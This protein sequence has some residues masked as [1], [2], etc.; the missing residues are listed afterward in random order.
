[1]NMT[2]NVTVT[3]SFLVNRPLIDRSIDP[4][5]LPPTCKRPCFVYV[6]QDHNEKILLTGTQKRWRK[7]Q[8]SHRGGI[9]RL[10]WFC[11]EMW[12][13]FKN[14]S[15]FWWKRGFLVQNQ[16]LSDT[17][18][19]DVIK[20]YQDDEQHMKNVFFSVALVNNKRMFWYWTLE[21]KVLC[22]TRTILQ[23]SR[24]VWEG[25]EIQLTDSWWCHRF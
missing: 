13:C 6:H 5:P 4:H 8:K 7:P 25:F 23:N 22:V 15:R 12:A 9:V 1:M 20:M 16:P 10:Q 19:R 17:I 24:S 21:V 14:Q 11:S 2:W 18:Q 3:G